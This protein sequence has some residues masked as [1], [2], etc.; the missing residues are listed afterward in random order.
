MSIANSTAREA[1]SVPSVPTAIFWTIALPPVADCRSAEPTPC[2]PVMTGV[3]VAIGARAR[4]SRL[5]RK[6]MRLTTG[7]QAAVFLV[8]AAV[9]IYAVVKVANG[10]AGWVVF[11]VIVMTAVGGAIAVNNRRFPAATKK[12]SFTRDSTS[13]W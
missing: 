12:R 5:E 11:G 8:F 1:V 7:I 4:A 6:R 10:W 13:R 9:L 2:A 3:T